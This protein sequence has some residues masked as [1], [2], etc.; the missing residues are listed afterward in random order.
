MT[1]N[2]FMYFVVIIIFILSISLVIAAPNSINV[3]GKLTNPS[4]TI[5]AG[6]FNFS[7]RFYDNYTAGTKLLEKN[8]TSTTDARGVYDIIIPDVNLTFKD[9]LYLGVEVNTDG[10]MSPRVNLTSVPYTFRANTSEALTPNSS[11]FVTNLSVNGNVT[12]GD[13]TTTLQITT[14][15]FNLSAIGDLNLNGSINAHSFIA[16]NSVGIGIA[17]PSEKL[18]VIGNVNISGYINM[19]GNLVTAGTVLDNGSLNKSIDLSS[20]ITSVTNDSLWNATG[21]DIFNREFDGRVGINTTTPAHTLTVHGSLNVT[22]NASGP[23]TL[24]V[25]SD[26]KVRI[27]ATPHTSSATGMPLLDIISNGT[28][29]INTL[30]VFNSQNT[31]GSGVYI[32]LGSSLPS[33]EH[34]SRI[35]ATREIAGNRRSTLQLQTHSSDSNTWN[36]GIYMDGLGN[37]GIGTANPGN[38]LHLYSDAT[39]QPGVDVTFEHDSTSPADH[40][41]NLRLYVKGDDSGGTSRTTHLIEFPISDVTEGTT[42]SSMAFWVMN[43]AAG[44]AVTV[45]SLTS[46]GVWQDSSAAANKAYEG[47]AV[48][49]WGDVLGK[50]AELETGI[51]HSSSLPEGEPV[52]ERHAGPTAEQFWDIFGLG[53]DPY[54]PDNIIGIGAKDLGALALA[55]VQELDKR[56]TGLYTAISTSPYTGSTTPSIYIDSEGNIGIGTTTPAYKLVV[57]GNVNISDSLNVT[58]TVQAT[59]FI[60]GGIVTDIYFAV[61]ELTDQKTGSTT[62]APLHGMAI[63]F[64]PKTPKNRILIQFRGAFSLTDTNGDYLSLVL[65]NNSAALNSNAAATRVRSTTAGDEV[66]AHQAVID[67][68][69]DDA[70]VVQHEIEVFWAVSGSTSEYEAVGHMRTLTIMELTK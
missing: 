9:Q 67:W 59:T 69:I 61:G 16:A 49:I 64:T 37:V 6:T 42:D 33:S 27:G 39:G 62:L 51:Y 50:I 45:A 14:Q 55:G 25:D 63:N 7:F 44:D 18:T 21:S 13:G 38:L 1:K 46:A 11:H 36:T 66:D 5:Q 12:I 40:D 65:Y 31:G 4:G 15:L 52:L 10:E 48:E 70:P 17:T 58:N 57:I 26:G 43:N 41:F 32:N 56:S 54:N 22:G 47:S 3:Q 20:Y 35:S 60:G 19:S 68:V 24:F 8:V 53:L 29:I 23:G 28:G 2:N 30:N 34:W